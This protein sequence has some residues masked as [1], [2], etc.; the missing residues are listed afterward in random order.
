MATTTPVRT[1]VNGKDIVRFDAAIKNDL[2]DVTLT[3]STNPAPPAGVS[4]LLLV[5]AAIKVTSGA[6]SVDPVVD[7]DRPLMK[8]FVNN[9][10][11]CVNANAP[12]GCF[13]IKAYPGDLDYGQVTQAR[14][15]GFEVTK[16][17]KSFEVT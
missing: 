12:K 11:N 15:I 9:N 1:S 4:G 13:P 14:T 2:P 10:G 17:V 7:W 5:P 16:N 6:G 3:T 8:L